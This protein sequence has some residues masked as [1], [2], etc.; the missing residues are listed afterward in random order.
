MVFWGWYVHNEEWYSNWL[1]RNPLLLW[2]LRFYLVMQT[3]CPRW[4]DS[5]KDGVA[6][7]LFG[8]LEQVWYASTLIWKR[9]VW[10]IINAVSTYF[11]FLI[12]LLSLYR[13]K[14]TMAEANMYFCC[15]GLGKYGDRA[16]WDVL[17]L[18]S[19]GKHFVSNIGIYN[20]CA[21][22]EIFQTLYMTTCH[23]CLSARCIERVVVFLN[24]SPILRGSL[25]WFHFSF[26]I[27]VFSSF[28]LLSMSLYMSLLILN[29][30]GKLDEDKEHNVVQKQAR[31]W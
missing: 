12:V 6:G 11:C 9:H 4:L 22:L 13:A 2:P 17:W 23:G 8:V 16:Y 7:C 31:V 30:G 24:F 26:F 14:M 21:A 29:N 25:C 10:S 18:V 3:A 27:S 5:E 19:Y 15:S 20:A 1:L 28:L